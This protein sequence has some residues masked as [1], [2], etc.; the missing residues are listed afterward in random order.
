[1]PADRR[2]LICTGENAMQ[3]SRNESTLKVTLDKGET[4]YMKDGRREEAAGEVQSP[5]FPHI[6]S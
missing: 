2:A 4:L 6:K 3:N 5:A 1:M